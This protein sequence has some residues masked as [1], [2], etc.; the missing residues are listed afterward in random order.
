[1]PLPLAQPANGSWPM[2]VNAW[3]IAMQPDTFRQLDDVGLRKIITA[4]PPSPSLRTSAHVPLSVSSVSRRSDFASLHSP[5][6][7]LRAAICSECH[8]SESVR[9]GCCQICGAKDIASIGPL[10][11]LSLHTLKIRS[12]PSDLS[13]NLSATQ[14][15]LAIIPPCLQPCALNLRH[16]CVCIHQGSKR[17]N[18]RGTSSS[19]C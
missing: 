16:L 14:I 1:M 15:G 13:G 8:A 3:A 18:R 9:F 4:S 5:S 10:R 12:V 6:T 11:A 19:A 7:R 17:E 2:A